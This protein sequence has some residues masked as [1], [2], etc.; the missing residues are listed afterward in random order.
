MKAKSSTKFTKCYEL[1]ECY[2]IEGKTALQF[3]LDYNQLLIV[4]NAIVSL[5][6]F[7]KITQA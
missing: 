7:A 5:I 1:F 3:S 2:D 6:A 4:I